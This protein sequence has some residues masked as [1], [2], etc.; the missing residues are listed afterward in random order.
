[1]F[2]RLLDEQRKRGAPLLDLTIS[3][4]TEV[5]LDYPH[6]AI[7]AVLGGIDDFT[8]PPVPGG[9][10]H[11]RA[12]I[13][14]YYEAR[15]IRVAPSQ[16]LLTSS[17]SEAYSL[18][19][20]LFCNAGDEVLVPQP[21]YPLFEYLAGL[22]CVRIVPYR[23]WYDAAW[24]VDLNSVEAALSR[25]TRVIVVVNP[26]NPTGSFVNKREAD[27]LR[28]IAQERSIPIVAD[29]VFGDY[30]LTESADREGFLACRD[31]GLTFSFNGLSKAAGMPQMKLGWMAI[32][33]ME[34]EVEIARD[35]LE[36]VL[37]T[38]LPVAGPIER[39][40]P[41]L[42]DIGVGIRQQIRARIKK[43]VIALDE[44]LR[45]SPAHALHTEG[46]WSA[47]VRLP[48][49]LSEDEW[50]A[51]LLSD[52]NIVVQPG[53]FFDMGSEAFVVVSLITQLETFRDGI[54][55]LREATFQY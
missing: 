3:N 12:V 50:I 49:Q 41:G 6:G 39:A 33:G 18:V 37:D 13:G 31:T 45:N 54:S 36:L 17:T 15:G 8:Y 10:A 26:N 21:S 25:N 16:V 35:R 53:Y 4:P 1:M 2:A 32:E 11:A 38:Y 46:G 28:A 9:S 40:L 34:P 23:L 43:N 30:P 48:G 27:G 22:E 20:R 42:L 7:A 14:N 44:I 29:E 52:W 24:F 47:I 51:R 5:G 55:R 19:L